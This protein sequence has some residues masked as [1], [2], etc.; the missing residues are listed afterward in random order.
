MDFL[1]KLSNETNRSKKEISSSLE[2]LKHM[3]FLITDD[4]YSNIKE[5]MNYRLYGNPPI[6][7]NTTEITLGP[8]PIKKVEYKRICNITSEFTDSNIGK[9]ILL[10]P[11]KYEYEH[12]GTTGDNQGITLEENQLDIFAMLINHIYD[13][14]NPIFTN[15]DI[16]W[17]IPKIELRESIFQ[18]FEIPINKKNLDNWWNIRISLSE[19][20]K[21]IEIDYESDTFMIP[22][23]IEEEWS[24][25]INDEIKL[26]I[27]SL[28]ATGTKN[29]KLLNID[30]KDIYKTLKEYSDNITN[31]S[32]CNPDKDILIQQLY[33]LN[34][35]SIPT[36]IS[37][38]LEFLMKIGF[39]I[40]VEKDKIYRMA[41]IEE[42]KKPEEVFKINN[43][44]KRNLKMYK[45]NHSI[46]YSF[47]SPKEYLE[48]T[49]K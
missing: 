6:K 39:V 18:D 14:D 35:L 33:K 16:F 12:F 46:I 2:E 4:V 32:S 5:T 42:I 11:A 45:K 19:N 3:G 1:E 44:W 28:Y 21:N 24:D 26:C 47:M 40:E 37:E 25:F 49:S 30:K 27:I 22:S 43:N 13:I 10:I 17:I 29:S 48:I 8:F 23:N 41:D 31:A 34:N 36:A 38:T 20:D 15:G 7:E 9:A